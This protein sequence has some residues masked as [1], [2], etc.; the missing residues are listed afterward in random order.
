MTKIKLNEKSEEILIK[1][2]E[3][4]LDP[5]EEYIIDL[6]YELDYQLAIIQSFNIMGPAPAIKNYHAWLKQNKF[7]VE[8]PNP[9]N[10]FVASFYGVRPLWKTAYSQGIVVRAINEDDYYIVMECSRE[11]KGY[12]YTKIILTLGGCM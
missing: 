1:N 5:T 3:Y 9:T 2:R 11:N 6:E 8:L 10:E 7:S 4:E 12:K